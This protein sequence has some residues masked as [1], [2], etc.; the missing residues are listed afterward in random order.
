ML[1]LCMYRIV[2]FWNIT[3]HT[4]FPLIF[5]MYPPKRHK[6]IHTHIQDRENT[7]SIKGIVYK[8]FILSTRCCPFFRLILSSFCCVIIDSTEVLIRKQGNHVF[9]QALSR[10]YS[11]VRTAGHRNML[12]LS[13]RS[14]SISHANT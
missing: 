13:I 1:S 2:F 6:P 10:T 3:I 5:L 8:V 7:T 4:P 11:T 14:L 9:F 12:P